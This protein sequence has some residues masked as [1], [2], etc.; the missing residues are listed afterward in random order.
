MV[1]FDNGKSIIPPV[2]VQQCNPAGHSGGAIGVSPK[3]GCPLEDPRMGAERPFVVRGEVGGNGRR[4]RAGAVPGNAS[5]REAAHS[6][7][8]RERELPA[9]RASRYGKIPERAE[10]PSGTAST[11]RCRTMR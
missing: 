1:L 4:R 9:V 3:G 11:I 5:H 2:R 6:R 10:C 7:T 8:P